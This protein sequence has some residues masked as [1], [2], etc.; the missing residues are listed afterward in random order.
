MTVSQKKDEMIKPSQQFPDS[1]DK[2]E[3]L[4]RKSEST[5]P[6]DLNLFMEPL[7]E[8]LNL[9]PSL[10]KISNHSQGFSLPILLKNDSKC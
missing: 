6:L 4:Q 3:I 1:D 5:R 8:G 7:K 2:N 9:N 10:R